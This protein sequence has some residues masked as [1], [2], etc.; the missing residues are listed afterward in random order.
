MIRSRVTLVVI[1][2]ICLIFGSSVDS[3]AL[4]DVINGRYLVTSYTARDYNG[5]NQ[6]WEILQD[7]QGMIYVANRDGVMVFDGVRWKIHSNA[8][9]TPLRSVAIEEHSNRIYVGSVGEFG[10]LH[11]NNQGILTYV[12]LS[13]NIEEV[14]PDVWETH[15]TQSGVY[16]VTR[17]IIYR[18]HDGKIDRI[19]FKRST[20]RSFKYEGSVYLTYPGEGFAQIAGNE[21]RILPGT[22]SI[23]RLNINSMLPAPMM[24][25]SE[26][27]VLLV[28]STLDVYHYGFDT[29][30]LTDL[31]GTDYARVPVPGQLY[32]SIALKNGYYAFGTLSNGIYITDK[33]FNVKHHIHR[34]SGLRMDMVLNMYEDK[35]GNLW[36]ALNNGISRIDHYQHVKAWDEHSGLSSGIMSMVQY[37]GHMYLGTSTGIYRSIEPT[38][39]IDYRF[40]QIDMNNIQAWE[41]LE[42]Q[43]RNGSVY[44]LIASSTGL[45]YWDGSKTHQL[46]G[47][48]VFRIIPS[49]NDNV[50]ILGHRQGWSVIELGV[51]PGGTLRL[52][53]RTEYLNPPF[54]IRSIYEDKDGNIWL[55]SRFNGLFRV[56]YPIQGDWFSQDPANLEIRHYTEENG[57]PDDAGN[58][59]FEIEGKMLI[60]TRDGL[61]ELN[62]ETGQFEPHQDRGHFPAKSITSVHKHDDNL[63]I[64]QQGDLARIYK[65][66]NSGYRYEDSYLPFLVLKPFST[67]FHESNDV[68][69]MGSSEGLYRVTVAHRPIYR[70]DATAIVRSV[71]IGSDSLIYVG[72]FVGG[73]AG[74]VVTLEYGIPQVIF[75]YG[76]GY[77]EYDNIPEFQTMLEGFDKAWSAWSDESR[78]TYTNLSNGRYVFKV[79]TRNSYGIPGPI[80]DLVIVVPTPWFKTWWAFVIYVMSGMVILFGIIKLNTINIERRNRELEQKVALR[81]ADLQ[82]EKRRLEEV[83]D[84]LKALD[85]NRDKFL[86][87][88]AHDLRNPLMIIRSSADLMEEEIDNK[89]SVIE[90]RGYIKDAAIKMQQIIE[91]LLEDRA[92]KISHR[93]HIGNVNLRTVIEKIL[94]ENKVW[95]ESKNLEFLCDLQDGCEIV[96]DSAQLGVIVENLI[97]N[98]IKYSNPGGV[99][100]VYLNKTSDSII[101]GVK[102][103]GVGLK[104]WE[105]KE[106]GKPFRKFG[107]PPTG[108]EDSSGMGLYI[109]KD[110]IKMHKGELFVTSEGIG[111]G[112]TFE[113]IFRLDN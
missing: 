112:S 99:V 37:Q 85:E 79:R 17:S 111:K 97:S 24:N 71:L 78:S 70:P 77:F 74:R 29:G 80:S 19:P 91:E 21:V 75:E 14:I 12:H 38:G 2:F 33:H 73:D 42:H 18:Y 48:G 55:G 11:P 62:E 27:G 105:I 13:E 95:I 98:A 15:V 110:L 5:G 54:E 25:D 36:A 61:M 57:L 104:A 102:D 40:S 58:G 53:Q 89:D 66:Q 65:D 35:Q 69:W 100:H 64:I 8:T 68:F 84:Q 45:F 47:N 3:Y 72:G 28:T 20:L 44:L 59:L 109:V 86:S 16:F 43:D 39:A 67:Q 108:G 52:V 10:Y 50:F 41:M 22:E 106:I 87:V 34:G 83:N 107:G 92:K 56:Q 90:F 63:W 93:E 9:S 76:T 31:S 6:N 82:V 7:S 81:T 32:R 101:L 51:G 49:R 96:G 46:D 30:K 103:Q 1:A 94:R 4:Q 23:G 60:A 26:H 113:I 88:V